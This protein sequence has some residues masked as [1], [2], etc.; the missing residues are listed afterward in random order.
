MDQRVTILP[1][2]PDYFWPGIA[3]LGLL[4]A[5]GLVYGASTTNGKSGGTIPRITVRRRQVR[6]LANMAGCRGDPY[7][8]GA[9]PVASPRPDQRTFQW[10][11]RRAVAGGR[12]PEGK[13][14]SACADAWEIRPRLTGRARTR[15][16]PGGQARPDLARAKSSK[17]KS[18]AFPKPVGSR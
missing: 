12:K 13:G 4:L 18:G 11:V 16:P 9:T 14:P 15:L 2:A 3:L 8:P 17:G 1:I 6:D 10:K 7:F 5:T